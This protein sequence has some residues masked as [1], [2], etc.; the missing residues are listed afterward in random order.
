[1][2]KPAKMPMTKYDVTDEVVVNASAEKIFNALV[3]V[4][5]GRVNWWL[6]HLSSKLRGGVSMSE[7]GS[8]FDVTVHTLIP[9][10]FTGKTVEVQRPDKLRVHYLGGAFQGEA[11]WTFEAVKGGTR[12]RLRWQTNPAGLLLKLASVCVPIGKGHSQVMQKGFARLNEYLGE[13][14]RVASAG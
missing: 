7:V 8:L 1:M 14:P 6:P 4:F 5:D 11:L 13:T 10:R 9:L 2:N 3:E 12:L